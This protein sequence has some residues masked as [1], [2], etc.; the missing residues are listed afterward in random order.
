MLNECLYKWRL[1]TCI[2]QI[3]LRNV[4]VNFVLEFLIWNANLQTLKLKLTAI[5]VSLSHVG[6]IQLNSNPNF[7]ISI[8]RPNQQHLYFWMSNLA[9]RKHFLQYS[10]CRHHLKKKNKIN[11][12][13]L[14]KSFADKSNTK[15]NITQWVIFC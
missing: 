5:I 2:R 10:Y 3:F 12:L 13:K 7:L 4:V 15:N 6:L 14:G 11:N 1:W 8:S 9:S